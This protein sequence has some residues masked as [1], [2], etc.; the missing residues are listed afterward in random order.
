[1]RLSFGVRAGQAAWQWYRGHRARPRDQTNP[2]HATVRG[3]V[4]E[5]VP[6]CCKCVCKVVRFTL[7]EQSK[8]LTPTVLA[9]LIGDEKRAGL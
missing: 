8:L 4:A 7:F 3:K 6:F 5:L 1:M 2:N 9:S